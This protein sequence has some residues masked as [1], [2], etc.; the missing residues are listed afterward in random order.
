MVVEKDLLR[1]DPCAMLEI[2]YFLKREEYFRTVMTAVVRQYHTTKSDVRYL[3]ND[4]R[5][6]VADNVRKLEIRV[7]QLRINIL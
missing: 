7:Q 2:R 4:L 1:D 3:Y 6:S 5:N